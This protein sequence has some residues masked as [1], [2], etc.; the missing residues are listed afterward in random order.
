MARYLTSWEGNT[1]PLSEKYPLL[2]ISSHPRYSFH[3]HGENVSWIRSIPFHR[4]YRDGYDCWPIQIHPSDADPRGIEDGDLV[5]AC[6]DR[7]EV[8]LIA[9]VTEKIRPGSVFSVSTGGYDPIEPGK[10]GSVDRGGAVNLLMPAK[11]MSQN[12]PG[13]VTQALVELEKW[14]G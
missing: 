2:L 12:A 14:E 8:V 9:R 3:T 10:I 13:Q 1:S 6:N 7:A 11:I 4:I 5:R